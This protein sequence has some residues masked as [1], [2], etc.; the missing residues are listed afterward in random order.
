MGPN[1]RFTQ[2]SSRKDFKD[3]KQNEENS[4]PAKNSSAPFRNIV[5]D[6]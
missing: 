2:D 3:R 1:S 6:I 5:N 4:K